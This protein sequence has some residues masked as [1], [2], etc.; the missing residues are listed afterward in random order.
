VAVLLASDLLLGTLLTRGTVRLSH[1]ARLPA[2][3][4]SE[5]LLLLAVGLD[6]PV[7]D[8]GT[9]RALSTDGRVEIVLADPE[10]GRVAAITTPDG[11]LRG[12]DLLV[13][14]S[15]EGDAENGTE[16]MGWEEAAGG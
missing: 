8:D 3:A 9:R 13:S 10:D 4:F 7:G 5:L 15:L 6:A 1:F 12:A 11:V 14:I 2:D 16:G